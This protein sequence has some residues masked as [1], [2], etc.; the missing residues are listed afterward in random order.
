[1]DDTDI[2]DLPAL[3]L[4]WKIKKDSTH[5]HTHTHY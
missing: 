4:N 5:T 2:P 1:L 3:S